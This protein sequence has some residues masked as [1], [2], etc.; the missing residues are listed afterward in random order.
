LATAG[1]V[2][3]AQIFSFVMTGSVTF[4]LYSIFALR[5]L[6]ASATWPTWHF[7]L[8]GNLLGF[9]SLTRPSFLVLFPIA[10]L[11]TLLRAHWFS[12]VRLRSAATA[13][14]AFT[15]AF[16]IIVGGW[17]TRNLH[18]VAKF[19]LTEEYGAVTLIERF[20]YNDMTAREFILA[21]PYCTPGIGDLTFDQVYGTD[22]M[23]RF[24]YHTGDSFFHV[25]RNH[26]DGLVAQ[27]GR[28]D[29]IIGDIVRS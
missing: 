28:L 19:G 26:R 25:G 17:A 7:I 9:L 3:G 11:L 8:A 5:I 4:S 10:V 22:S 21:F 13:I 27:H 14:L 24:V 15:L 23:H 2:M 1:L 16:S 12:P 6:S 20:A 18:S 29:P